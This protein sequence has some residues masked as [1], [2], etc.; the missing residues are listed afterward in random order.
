MLAAAC[1]VL[2]R[3]QLWAPGSASDAVP[4][5]SRAS[6][7]GASVDARAG[8]ADLRDG[9]GAAGGWQI[10]AR[11]LRECKERTRE[12][13]RRP[14]QA[15]ERQRHTFLIAAPSPDAHRLAMLRRW[16][17]AVLRRPKS[18]QEVTRARTRPYEAAAPGVLL[19][20]DCNGIWRWN[21]KPRS[22]RAN[23]EAVA[24][25]GHP[26]LA[27]PVAGT[28]IWLLPSARR[29][30][31]QPRGHLSASHSRRHVSLMNRRLR[32]SS[33]QASKV[34]CPPTG[35]CVH[36]L[37]VSRASDADQRPDYRLLRARISTPRFGR[38]VPWSRTQNAGRA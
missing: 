26:Q 29:G 32:R 17:S 12:R 2:P 24:A 23:R 21:R 30:A 5:C 35:R 36:P 31:A 6:E 3:R 25:C 11:Q 16:R 38:A 4:A 22:R 1:T 13:M 19:E 37:G 14:E 20:V 18:G 8:A 15:R 28:P 27:L 7:L 34:R 33:S 9:S 10:R